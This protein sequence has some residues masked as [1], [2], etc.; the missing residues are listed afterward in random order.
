MN[1]RAGALYVGTVESVELD[2]NGCLRVRIPALNGLFD[3][4]VAM[5]LAGAGRGMVFLPEQADQVLLGSVNGSDV[6]FVLLGSLLSANAA[7]PKL[8]GA[9]TNDTKLIQTRGGNLIRLIDTEGDES[10][11][12]A[13]KDRQRIRFSAKDDSVEISTKGGGVKVYAKG[14]AINIKAKTI[15]LDGDV[16]VRGELKVGTNGTTTIAG[17]KIAGKS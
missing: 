9:P 3:C 13:T 16:H 15:T 8:D 6:E 5:P 12:I 2:A 4:R 1:E 14:D 10:I 7:P 17:N 11:E